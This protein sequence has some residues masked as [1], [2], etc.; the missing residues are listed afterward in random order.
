MQSCRSYLVLSSSTANTLALPAGTRAPGADVG[1]EQD[2]GRTLGRTTQYL[3]HTGQVPAGLPHAAPEDDHFAVT[4]PLRPARRASWAP[5]ARVLVSGEACNTGDSARP[6]VSARRGQP[7]P[8]GCPAG[9]VPGTAPRALGDA[10]AGG[11]GGPPRQ[12]ASIRPR[13]NGS[14]GR[15]AVIPRG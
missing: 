8:H 11:M 14:R 15:D 7:A 4:A 2:P 6:P 10:V 9:G 5:V 13:Y 1:A 3:V 12:R